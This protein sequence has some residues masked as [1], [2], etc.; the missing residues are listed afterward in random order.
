MSLQVSI[1][2]ILVVGTGHI[3]S[4]VARDLAENMPSLELVIAD[5]SQSRGD[6][7]AAAIGK[8]SVSSIALD[9]SDRKNLINTLKRFDLVVGAL[10]GEV[11]YKLLKGCIEARVNTVDVSFMPEDPFALSK[12]AA[13]AGVT[14]IP[15]CG[16][17]P[18]LSHMLV[19]RGISK[20]DEVKN[21]QIM[22]GGLPEKPIQPLGYTITW[23]VE[24]LIDE[25]M[26]KARIIK[27]GKL[28]E[29]DP[30]GDVEEAELPGV[31]KL[32]AFFSDGLRT[33]LQT[34]KGVENMAE[35]TLRY[36]G[37]VE[38]I[39]LL[40]DLGLLDE[41]SIQVENVSVPPR[42]VT[43]KLLEKKLKKPDVPDILVMLVQVEGTKDGK[44]VMHSYYVLDRFDKKKKVTAMARTT[45]YTASCMTQLLAK[46]VIKIRGMVPPEK[47]G[48]DKNVFKKLTGL[49]KKRGILVKEG[50]K[51][52]I[53]L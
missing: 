34:V 23:S 20:L 5:K 25:Y 13:N 37:H 46:K 7:V 28:I 42:K 47:L 48:R 12:A 33:L 14:I 29:V 4:I 8:K 26:R 45:G 43:V 21:A 15:D 27:N 40:R 41:K 30:L 39:R 50:K 53:W 11:G 2:K 44:R 35:K 22:V 38:K 18:G 32:E 10:P 3:G 1:M 36:P 52:L 31:G 51:I 19:Q 24:G 6:E 16:V 49:L 9:V 17:A